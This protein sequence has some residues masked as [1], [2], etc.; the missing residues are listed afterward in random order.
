[1][2]C[3]DFGL[4]YRIAIK[5]NTT[6]NQT[7]IYS[8]LTTGQT[9]SD[10][11][12]DKAIVSK[13]FSG[14][15]GL[16]AATVKALQSV[17]SSEA[18]RR[19]EL[20]KLSDSVTAVNKLWNI[21]VHEVRISEEILKDLVDAVSFSASPSLFLTKAFMLSLDGPELVESP[22][23]YP[24]MDIWGAITS[25]SDLM[26]MEQMTKPQ[27]DALISFV[28]AYLE[29]E[30][31]SNATT[32]HLD[33]AFDSYVEK[34]LPDVAQRVNY[35][36]QF[37]N[38]KVRYKKSLH[39]I[40]KA[41]P[42]VREDV[43][44]EDLSTE[45]IIDFLDYSRKVFSDFKSDLWSEICAYELN[46]PGSISRKLL[47]TIYLM[48]DKE[49]QA[50]DNLRRVCFTDLNIQGSTLPLVFIRDYP[51]AYSS[52]EG[53]AALHITTGDLALLQ[54]DA[55]IECNYET[56]FAIVGDAALSYRNYKVYIEGDD[57]SPDK[58]NRVGIGNVRFTRYG[59]EL[60]DLLQSSRII[61]LPRYGEDIF[62]F[63][64]QHW[65]SKKLR[66]RVLHYDPNSQMIVET[67]YNY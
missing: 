28:K 18:K 16:P 23:S 47:M 52:C 38:M 19:I 26:A 48:S 31:F 6:R 2:P 43:R 64:I 34:N 50:F 39:I 32:S 42:Y 41:L 60:F 24:V 61:P 27:R 51:N 36:V 7:S 10:K 20:L 59:Q 44:P 65:N 55:L 17:E 35:I 4:F 45:W 25:P 12:P 33:E 29:I 3:F 53:S 56:G 21:L 66:M 30:D 54:A 40:A 14:K 57:N 13:I 1:M 11:V 49:L 5:G 22:H 37:R 67:K 62:G 46:N 9:N 15:C 8:I 63:T 58:V